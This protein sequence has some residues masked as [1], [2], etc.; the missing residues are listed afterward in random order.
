MSVKPVTEGQEK[1]L[2]TLAERARGTFW[3]YIGCEVMEASTAKVVLRLQAQQHHL[4]VIGIVHG[5]VLSSLLDNAMGLATMLLRPNENTVTSNLN[6]N[7]V[8]PMKA[9]ELVVTAEVIH[10][11]GRTLT[12]TGK[13]E[14][15]NGILG[16]MGTGTFRVVT[17]ITAIP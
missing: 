10:Q 13:V 8:A 6:V 14:S 3:D 1:W 16:T 7:F 12:C 2:N 17:P 15:S 9:G 11:S 4:N 5:G